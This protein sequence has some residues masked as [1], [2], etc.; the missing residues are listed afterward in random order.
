MSAND[1]LDKRRQARREA[2]AWLSFAAAVVASIGFGSVF[3]F[4]NLPS[5]FG[6]DMQRRLAGWELFGVIGV[7]LVI[8]VFLVYLGAITWLL[9]A[10]FFFSK[11]EVSQVVFHGPTTRF[12]R[13]LVDVLFP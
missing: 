1:F 8:V 3:A 6:V 12:E 13:W 4:R 5:H 11:L 9:F 10:R 2:F 7:A